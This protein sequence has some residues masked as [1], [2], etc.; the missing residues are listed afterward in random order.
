MNGK[1]I[2]SSFNGSAISNNSNLTIKN[3]SDSESIV[4]TSKGIIANNE[5]STLNLDNVKC[6]S[7]DTTGTSAIA[8]YGKLIVKKSHIE[9]SYGIGF[10]DKK[11]STFDIYDSEIIGTNNHGIALNSGSGA[12]GNIYNSTI[13]GKNTAIASSSAGTIN[14]YSGT[15]TGETANGIANSSTGTI[16][17]CSGEISGATYDLNNSSTGII[18]YTSKVTLKNSTKSGTNINLTDD[19]VCE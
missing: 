8:N 11:T 1:S 6:I 12:N 2:N 18:N 15:F 3:S 16:N 14:I 13:T 4:T 10:N 19:I 9:G 7:S 17:I 5:N